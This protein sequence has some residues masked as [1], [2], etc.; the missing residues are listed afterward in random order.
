VEI[1]DGGKSCLRYPATTRR[2]KPASSTGCCGSRLIG[3]P[4][5]GDKNRSIFFSASRRASRISFAGPARGLCDPPQ[6]DPNRLL[7]FVQ[8][9]APL[10]RSQNH[11]H[12]ED[13]FIGPSPGK[14]SALMCGTNVVDKSR[15][16]LPSIHDL[17]AGRARF[18]CQKL[19]FNLEPAQSRP[20]SVLRNRLVLGGGQ[21]AF[22]S[23]RAL[24]DRKCRHPA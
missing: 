20:W 18:V 24:R 19:D 6:V 10:P 13:V 3:R 23:R 4:P 8:T 7:A 5:P 11:Q 16:I 17:I 22:R 1:G 21:T 14:P 15:S 2:M 9:A 12:A